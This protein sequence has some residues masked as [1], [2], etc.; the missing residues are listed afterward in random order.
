M[1]GGGLRHV[2]LRSSENA[3]ASYEVCHAQ[4]CAEGWDERT[5]RGGGALDR[6]PP[7]HTS[8]DC[9]MTN[10]VTRVSSFL[11]SE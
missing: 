2:L 1:G 9:E 5:S 8:L 11:P 7:L 6:G 3:D 4:C 10:M